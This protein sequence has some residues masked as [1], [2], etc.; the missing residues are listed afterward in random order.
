MGAASSDVDA[1]PPTATYWQA[2]AARE[3][4]ALPVH[5]APPPNVD[6]A[7]VGAG[8]V[9]TACAYW[10][11][12]LGADVALLEADRVACG[13]S[14]RNG[15]FMLGSTAQ[16]QKLRELLI[17]E[18]IGAELEH[19]GHL[20]LASS[21]AVLDAFR[22]ELGQRPPDAPRIELLD[23]SDC[24][25]LLG[26]PIA[27]RFRGA[28]WQPSGA[29]VQPVRFVLGLA[30]GAARR[31]A[32]VVERCAVRSLGPGRRGGVLVA[33]ERGSVAARHVVVACA[34][35]SAE[36][37]PGGEGL[38]APVRGQV[39]A[40][41]PLAR[42]FAPGMAVDF[43]DVYWRQ[44]RDGTIVI[45]GCRGADPDP[46]R[47]R[48]G[49]ETVNPRVQRA[50]ESFLP[51]AFPGFGPVRVARRWAGVMDAA[52]DG[53]PLVGRWPRLEGL[54]V[55]AG[56]GGHGLPPASGVGRVI[57]EAIVHGRESDWLERLAPDRDQEAVAA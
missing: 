2:A 26:I 25:D 36:L 14:G 38:L 16:M 57:A 18:R 32:H 17:A 9:G 21:D 43:G 50:L 41:E 44:A 48:S 37:L 55:A 23:R 4:D 11:A 45:G 24:E 49:R 27:A 51:E 39:L 20:A 42:R 40:T 13:A 10:L 30:A 28:R 19:P 29:T 54:W 53:R 8:V 6:V 5:A 22:A 7:V 46:E 1:G 47:E 35:R 52:R 31:G 34:A 33:T 3:R 15:G 12:R 56:F